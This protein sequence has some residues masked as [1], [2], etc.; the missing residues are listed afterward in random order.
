MESP[1][2]RELACKGRR[3]SLLCAL[4]EVAWQYSLRQERTVDK[5]YFSG[6]CTRCRGTDGNRGGIYAEVHI[7]VCI[8]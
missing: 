3:R 7:R 1:L 5:S 8:L 6:A 4:V 2:L